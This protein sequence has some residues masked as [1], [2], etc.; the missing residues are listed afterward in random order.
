MRKEG[1]PERG[2]RGVKLSACS[3]KRVLPF[4]V[5]STPCRGRRVRYGKLRFPSCTPFHPPGAPLPFGIATRRIPTPSTFWEKVLVSVPVG[6]FFRLSRGLCALTQKE[7]QG[8]PHW[9]EARASIDACPG[10]ELRQATCRNKRHSM[11]ERQTGQAQPEA[12][13]LDRRHISRRKI[14]R[15]LARKGV[16][17]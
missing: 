13:L 5:V 16:M 10:D 11:G 4:L 1:L 3:S 14:T 9:L 7:C 17:L 6:S 12:P 8:K 15:S 2:V